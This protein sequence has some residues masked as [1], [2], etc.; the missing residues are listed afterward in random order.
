MDAIRLVQESNVNNQVRL[1]IQGSDGAGDKPLSIMES[2]SLR[3]ARLR[4]NCV[5]VVRTAS[6]VTATSS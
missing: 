5:F 2:R 3:C 4:I 1:F 6:S